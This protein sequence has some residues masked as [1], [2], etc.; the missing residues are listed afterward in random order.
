[1]QTIV[2]NA[3]LILYSRQLYLSE[4]TRG[5]VFVFIA[6]LIVHLMLRYAQRTHSRLA[7]N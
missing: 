2:I 6:D 5:I 4:V 3:K 1:M 7:T